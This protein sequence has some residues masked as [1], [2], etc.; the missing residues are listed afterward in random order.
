MAQAI[1]RN[2]VLSGLGVQDLFGKE[3]NGVKCQGKNKKE[4]IGEKISRLA[5]PTGADA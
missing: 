4:I 1:T 5:C 2:F 3:K